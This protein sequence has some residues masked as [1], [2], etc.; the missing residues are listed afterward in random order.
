MPAVRVSG[1]VKIGKRN[2]L[3]VGSAI[4]QQIKVGSDTVIGANS[5]VIRSTKDRNTY[6]G[7]PACIVKY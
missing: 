5:V 7:N 1:E 3:G 4:L 6:V 2:F